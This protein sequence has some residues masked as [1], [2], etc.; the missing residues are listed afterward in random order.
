M[1]RFCVFNDPHTSDGPPLGRT[2]GYTDQI[3][4]KLEEVAE[5]A[6][7]ECCDL[8]ICPGDF[9]HRK[10]PA[11]V[12][13]GLVLRS[14]RLYRDRFAMPVIGVPGNH[15]MTYAALESLWKQPLGV[16]E[17]AKA[18]RLLRGSPQKPFVFEKEGLSVAFIG[19]PYSAEGTAQASYYSLTP[20]EAEVAAKANLSVMVAHG[21]VLPPGESR[22]FSTVC[23]ENID[24]AGP[25][26]IMFCGH[27]HEKLGTHDLPGGGMFIN[28]GSIARVS[29]TKENLSGDAR[30]VL[31][32]TVHEDGNV[33]FEPVALTSV[34]PPDEVFIEPMETDTDNEEMARFAEQLASGLALEEQSIDEALSALGD[35]PSRVKERLRE[36]LERG[37]L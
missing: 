34:L 20:G 23:A 13:H 8:A 21:D 4:S 35:I 25:V 24:F 2:E 30:E 1:I 11:H 3:I 28:L 26:D 32:V 14:I 18:V 29:R 37:G 15:D 12:T 19:R 31:I 33:G 36:Y 16:L 6:G 7:R 22:P 17:W 27:L 5:I 9:F 10:H